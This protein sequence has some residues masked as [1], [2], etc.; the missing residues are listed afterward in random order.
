MTFPDIPG[1]AAEV[2]RTIQEAR[3]QGFM[4]EL[5]AFYDSS[6]ET[7]LVPRWL[8]LDDPQVSVSSWTDFPLFDFDT[9][10]TRPCFAYTAVY[11]W[12]WLKTF[13]IG[14]DDLVIT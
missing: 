8:R 5:L 4:S 12:S 1:I 3:R 6:K 13:G 11:A 7:P 9:M 2:R 10:D 14:L